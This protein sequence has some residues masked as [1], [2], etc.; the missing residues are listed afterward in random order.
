MIESK[1]EERDTLTLCGSRR[2][3]VGSMPFPAAVLALPLALPASQMPSHNDPGQFGVLP[4]TLP[5][6]GAGQ[7]TLV[8]EFKGIVAELAADSQMVFCFSLPN[9]L[10]PSSAMPVAAPS[11]S[12]LCRPTPG[13]SSVGCNISWEFRSRNREPIRSVG[14]WPG[15]LRISIKSDAIP[16]LGPDQP[17]CGV[18]VVQHLHNLSLLQ[19]QCLFRGLSRLRHI[20]LDSDEHLQGSHGTLLISTAT[21]IS[22]LI[23]LMITFDRVGRDTA[24]FHRSSRGS[25]EILGQIGNRMVYFKC[26]LSPFD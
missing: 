11:N 6:C 23:L 17:I 19:A 5:P 8:W 3:R 13:C 16:H 22:L 4:R 21:L 1:S 12:A 14:A 10:T 9:P 20:V 25:E 2:F 24:G 7:G 18:L 26:S 15:K